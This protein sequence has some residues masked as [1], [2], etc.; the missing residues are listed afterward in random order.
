M[1]STRIF[2]SVARLA[3]MSAIVPDSKP[4]WTLAMSGAAEWTD[5]PIAVS[6]RGGESTSPSTMSRSWI[7]RSITTLSF[8]TRGAKGPRRRDSM[9][10]GRSTIFFSSCT[11]PLNRST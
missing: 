4:I 1:E 5:D 6:R 10:I 7:I 11:A 2:S 9:R 3:V 8:C